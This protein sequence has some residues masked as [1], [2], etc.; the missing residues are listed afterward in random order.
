MVATAKFSLEAAHKGECIADGRVVDK[1]LRNTNTS[2]LRKRTKMSSAWCHWFTR[3][4]S[5]LHLKCIVCYSNFIWMCLEKS[6]SAVTRLF[7]N[8][9]G[10]L[11][12]KDG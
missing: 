3:W 1:K 5:C 7:L 11:S 12:P 6:S 2:L 9:N 8:V 4:F 10:N